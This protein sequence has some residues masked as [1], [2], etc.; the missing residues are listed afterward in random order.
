MRED[1]PCEVEGFAAV[2]GF[3]NDLHVVLGVDERCEAAAH[4]SLIV[5][6]EDKGPSVTTT[7]PQIESPCRRPSGRT[8]R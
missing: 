1:A 4:G 8:R 7:T 3:P 2:G 5:R 6:D